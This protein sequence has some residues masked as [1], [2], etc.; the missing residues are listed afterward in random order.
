ML[1]QC[2]VVVA[3]LCFYSYS[4]SEVLTT[5]T[6]NAAEFG[7]SWAIK[8]VLPQ[9][10]GLD[11]IGVNYRYTAVKATQDPFVVTVG[12]LNAKNNY[13]FRSEDNWTGLPSN[14]ITKTVPVVDYSLTTWNRGHIT[15]AGLGSVRDSYVSYIY[16][17][18]SCKI[19]P[20]VDTS[21]PNYRPSVPEVKLN[22][23][24]SLDSFSLNNSQFIEK[25]EQ[26]LEKHY[27]LMQQAEDRK[28]TAVSRGNNLLI[29]SVVDAQ[30]KALLALNNRA[31]FNQYTIPLAGG[32]YPET[33]R[34][35]DKVLPDS[36]SAR[37]FNLS[38]QRL[39]NAMIELQYTR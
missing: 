23:D 6:N 33:L 3:F 37:R 5:R 21:C 15:T 11:V 24:S 19:D 38:Q 13:V 10:S 18:D 8:Q 1:K 31:D 29:T 35:V 16:R 2:L 26:T 27:R 9:I 36:S 22:I 30:L 39:H 32:A 7:L 34:Y 12:T 4:Y 14:T 17:Y 25:E 28:V 20:V